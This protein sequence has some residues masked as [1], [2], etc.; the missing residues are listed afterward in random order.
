MVSV[1]IPTYNRAHTLQKSIESVLSQTYS[2]LELIVVDDG[3]TDNTEETVKAISDRRLRYFYQDHQG[4][5]SARNAGILLARGEYIAFQDSDDTWLPCKL[6][7]Q[8]QELQKTG[9]DIITCHMLMTDKSGN[10][11]S[12]PNVHHS[13]FFTQE[14]IPTGI[15]TQTLLMKKTVADSICF[16]PELPRF[17][18]MEWLLRA[19]QKYRVYCMS[20]ALV[21]YRVYPDSISSS[22]ENG[23]HAVRIIR[24]KHPD[25]KE[26][27]PIIAESLSNAMLGW[28]DDLKKNGAQN[29]RDYLLLGQDL[30]AGPRSRIKIVLIKLNLYSL[31]RQL[32]RILKS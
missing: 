3:S 10:L 7:V 16:D 23:Y 22:M 30:S 28:S 32:K 9:A 17:Q 14:N 29:Y 6:E 19:L 11:I 15:G 18:D 1:I 26:S 24:T 25:L 4:A 13:Q 20:Q 31:F 5:C 27:A 12:I 2:D 8:L 21:N